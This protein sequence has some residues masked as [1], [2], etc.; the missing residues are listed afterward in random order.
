MATGKKYYWI[1]LRKDFMTSD[2]VDFLMGQR[3]GAQ[4]V[5]LY[6]MLCLMC[7][8][9]N[10]EL[11]RQI[12]EVMIPFDVDKIARDC[13]YFSRDTVTIA[14]EL[15][16]R[17]GLIY[18]QESGNLIISGFE[19][20]IGCET[21]YAKQKRVQRQSGQIKGQI[22]GQ[23]QD[24]S[25]DN[26][27]DNVQDSVSC[28]VSDS[29]IQS[30]SIEKD[31]SIITVSNETV[32][33]TD[34]RLIVDAWNG[35][36]SYGIKPISKLSSNSKRFQS[37]VARMKQYSTTDILSAI[38]KI[39]Q[40]DFLQGKN[41]SG[42]MITFDWFVLPNNFPKVLEGNYDNKGMEGNQPQK[43]AD[44]YQ[45]KTSQMLD[46]SYEMMSEWARKK[47]MEEHDNDN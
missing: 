23:I 44:Q 24:S 25:K 19:N 9:T 15:F 31:E 41:N 35:L 40:S 7:I 10:G 17:L 26:S 28:V 34:V 36:Q 39:K 4:Y 11:A 8:N 38:D 42:W 46:Q 43:Y 13:K 14:L 27:V 16:K 22:Q 20:L 47:E 32:R 3:N 37:L 2:T 21:D 1:K 45:S 30:K 6:Q 12:G 33:Q 29:S 18:E 5:V